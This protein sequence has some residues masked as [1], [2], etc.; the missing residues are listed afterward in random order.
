MWEND[1]TIMF[2]P[3]AISSAIYKSGILNNQQQIRVDY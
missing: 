3:N 2:T 1:Y